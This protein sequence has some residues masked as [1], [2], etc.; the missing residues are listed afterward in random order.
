M[1]CKIATYT[2]TLKIFSG[3]IEQVVVSEKRHC[4][5]P[6]EKIKAESPS[7]FYQSI[8]EKTRN[9]ETRA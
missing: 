3:N 7:G 6:G 1:W 4:E 9:M 5:N 8:D 2:Q